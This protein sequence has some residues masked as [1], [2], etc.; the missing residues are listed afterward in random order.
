MT[1]ISCEPRRVSGPHVRSHHVS[2]QSRKGS[3]DSENTL[4]DGFGTNS[5]RESTTKALIAEGIL[6]PTVLQQRT[7]TA[8]RLGVTSDHLSAPL[9]SDV[10]TDKSG[11]KIAWDTQVQW[12]G[13]SHTP[14]AST[15]ELTDSSG[16]DTAVD[17][18]RRG[19]D[20]PTE[21]DSLPSPPVTPTTLVH[22]RRDSELPF[23]PREGRRDS[24]APSYV[25]PVHSTILEEPEPPNTHTQTRASQRPE[26]SSFAEILD[27]LDQE[28]NDER[29][30]LSADQMNR[31]ASILMFLYPFAVRF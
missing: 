11:D 21:T 9:P 6:S 15:M 27:I 31:R 26:L 8:P 25:G 24:G 5:R 3:K 18:L 28:E 22:G 16:S 30:P 4:I 12:T 14:A 10:V 7:D 1:K 19:S 2:L 17:S 13:S 20:A 29:P 23:L